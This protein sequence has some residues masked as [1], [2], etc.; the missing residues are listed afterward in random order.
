MQDSLF[1][2]AKIATAYKLC[3]VDHQ[4]T[5]AKAVRYGPDAWL[6]Y[7][8]DQPGEIAFQRAR[9]IS[10][11]LELS[12][13]AHLREWTIS[14]TSVLL[15]FD[16]RHCPQ[17]APDF[18]LHCLT[19]GQEDSP[20]KIIPVRYDGPDL[21]RVATHTGLS[22][23]AIIELHC[24]PLYQVQCLGF[25]PGFPYLSGLDARLHTPRL[26]TPRTIIPAGSVAIGGSQ[27]GIYPLPTPGGW[28][29]IGS[30]TQSLFDPHQSITHACFL[31]A[32]D[33]VKFVATPP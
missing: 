15:E 10:R 9:H 28:N 27:T 31:K 17:Q 5:S 1:P 13:P 6:L 33:L 25:A 2:L 8:A 7:F 24:A 4:A 16:P 3:G 30:T 18:P 22:I 29:I 12:P 19:E 21:A 32:G 23:D 14:Y 11:L 26:E 20:A